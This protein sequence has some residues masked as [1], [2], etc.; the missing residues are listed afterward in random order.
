MGWAFV[1]L[2]EGGV[3]AVIGAQMAYMW[4]LEL[5]LSYRFASGRWREI[6]MVGG[7]PA[8]V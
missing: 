5:A 4:V 7:E 1:V 2:F 6:D 8:L 3:H